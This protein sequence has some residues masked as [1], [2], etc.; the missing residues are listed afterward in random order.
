MFDY[1]SVIVSYRFKNQPILNLD[2]N[3]AHS[4]FQM[5]SRLRWSLHQSRLERS[6]WNVV[7]WN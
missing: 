5:W 6:Q 4:W 3:F 1:V 2:Q 7:W